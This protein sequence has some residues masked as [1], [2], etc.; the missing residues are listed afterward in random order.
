M[1]AYTSFRSVTEDNTL[2]HYLNEAWKFPILKKET[3]VKLAKKLQKTGDI[4]AA[5][6]LVTSHLRLVAKIAMG[7][8]GYGLPVIDLVAE[9]NIGLMKAVKKFDPELGFRL[10]TYAMWWIRASITEY[11]LRSW[12]LV[13][14]G[15]LA[16]Q[17]KMFFKLRKLKE[18]LKI[19][20]NGELDPK[21]AKDISRILRAS[22]KEVLI[23]N[24]RLS[25][26]DLS[27]NS[28]TTDGKEGEEYQD[29]LVSP[30]SSPETIYSNLEEWSYRR[31]I[32]NSAIQSLSERERN[33]FVERRLKEN[34]MTLSE[35]GKI[36]NVSRE[37]IRQ[38][39]NGAFQKVGKGVK[40][41]TKTHDCES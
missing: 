23:M 21:Q 17:K 2:S 31:N 3:E 35:L 19:I 38:I 34:P 30:S 8:R 11:V 25:G 39:E 18:N 13:K 41:I 32:V 29:K 28:P 24:R 33:I 37:R 26:R 7:Y 22:E 10:S 27:L 20:D 5:H 1:V 15:T 16:S 12:S 9:G 4:K 6:Q 14:I 40:K 36:Y